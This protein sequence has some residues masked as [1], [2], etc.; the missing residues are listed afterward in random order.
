MR[1]LG[2]CSPVSEGRNVLVLSSPWGSPGSVFSKGRSCVCCWAHTGGMMEQTSGI[3]DILAREWESLLK[4][5]LLS[6]LGCLALLYSWHWPQTPAQTRPSPRHSGHSHCWPVLRV[7]LL[8]GGAGVWVRGIAQNSCHR[9]NSWAWWAPA[10][11]QLPQASRDPG[12][13]GLEPGRILP[14]LPQILSAHLGGAWA[15]LGVVSEKT[16]PNCQ[17]TRAGL[18]WLISLTKNISSHWPDVKSE[19]FWGKKIDK[20]ALQNGCFPWQNRCLVWVFI[21]LKSSSCF[22]QKATETGQSLGLVGVLFP[23]RS[24]SSWLKEVFKDGPGRKTV[25]VS[26]LALGTVSHVTELSQ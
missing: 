15:K 13:E 3:T 8:R 6:P 2:L 16:P 26:A 14:F 19:K 17:G 20:A 24:K 11:C 18:W 7:L 1:S 23:Q 9:N 10:S 21:A 4:M 12:A 22:G 5:G 25:Q